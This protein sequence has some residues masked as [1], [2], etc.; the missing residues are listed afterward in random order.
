MC[1]AVESNFATWECGRPC[2]EQNDSQLL[3]L[4][5]GLTALNKEEL[6]AGEGAGLAEL[7]VRVRRLQ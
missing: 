7:G 6:Q 4:H 2:V 3:P 1:L 5:A